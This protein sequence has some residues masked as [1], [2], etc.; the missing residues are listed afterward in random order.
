MFRR[1][2]RFSLT[3]CLGSARRPLSR[4]EK[5]LPARKNEL[6]E[7]TQKLVLTDIIFLRVAPSLSGRV[8]AWR[9][10]GSG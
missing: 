7:L 9:S 5:E 6:P 10:Q 4:R 8:V 2:L 1:A 3:Y